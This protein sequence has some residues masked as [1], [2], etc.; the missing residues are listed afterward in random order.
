MSLIQIL[1]F[2]SFVTVEL[3][4]R[5]PSLP[6][7]EICVKQFQTLALNLVLLIWDRAC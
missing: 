2:K 1:I 5:I 4:V 6:A 3:G 7:L